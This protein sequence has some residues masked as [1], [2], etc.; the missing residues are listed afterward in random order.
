MGMSDRNQKSRDRFSST[1]I[2][3]VVGVPLLFFF[4][5]I[6][7]VKIENFNFIYIA[8]YCMVCFIAPFFAKWHPM[9]N[10]SRNNIIVSASLM[11]LQYTILRSHY[12][13]QLTITSLTPPDFLFT[14]ILVGYFFSSTGTALA[15]RPKRR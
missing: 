5:N 9:P 1:L 7:A 6:S 15:S 11:A 13:I 2:L 8:S 10:I 14:N 12:G 4:Y 3:L